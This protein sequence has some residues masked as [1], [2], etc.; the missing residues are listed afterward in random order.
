M[1]MKQQKTLPFGLSSSM[2]TMVAGGPDLDSLH[3]GR[4]AK[5]NVALEV[6][7]KVAESTVVETL[8][9]KTQEIC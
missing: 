2:A 1:R 7:L 4:I 5:K 9:K 8:E 3:S 6:A